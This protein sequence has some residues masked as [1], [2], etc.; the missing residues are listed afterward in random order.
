MILVALNVQYVA[1]SRRDHT[2]SHIGEGLSAG[3]FWLLAIFALWILRIAELAFF[4]VR[5]SVRRESA[6]DLS[7]MIQVCTYVCGVFVMRGRTRGFG[8]GVERGGS[9]T[10]L[11]MFLRA[12]GSR[13]K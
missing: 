12:F 13:K 5:E 8:Q 2:Q 6:A 4:S 1:R 10:M 3:L 7:A 11:C 9:G